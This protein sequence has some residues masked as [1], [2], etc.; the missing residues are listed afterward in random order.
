MKKSMVLAL[1][2]AAAI[3]FSYVLVSVKPLELLVKELYPGRVELL[4]DLNE[5]PHM[6]SLTP[7]TMRK[8][9]KSDALIIFGWGFEEWAK[10]LKG[11]VCIAAKGFEKKMEKNPHIWLSLEALPKIAENVA[12]C[13]EKLYPD[14]KEEIGKRLKAFKEKL[15]EVSEKIR[16]DLLG[17]RAVL[18]EV[19]PALYHFVIP[20][21][22]IEYV[23][24]VSQTQPSLSPKRLQQVISICRKKGVKAVLI[25][26][27]TSRKIVEPLVR[28]CKLR[29]ITVDVLGSDAKDFF[30]MLFSVERSVLEA[31]E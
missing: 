30:E 11:R 15:K 7:S 2:F 10:K 26:R 8:V 22:N 4:I 21:E 23:T 19:R 20:Y 17:K 9:V 25:E 16:K 31:I 5:N 1:L 27:N 24:L 14:M 6:F 13:L 3:S 12:A 28:E 29:V 18:M